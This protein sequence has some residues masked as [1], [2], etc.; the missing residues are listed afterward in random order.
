MSKG[1]HC[2]PEWTRGTV[3]TVTCEP[4]GELSQNLTFHFA[5]AH[6]GLLIANPRAAQYLQEM[7]A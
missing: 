4:D 3:L 5:G 2:A 1:I 6:P 7:P